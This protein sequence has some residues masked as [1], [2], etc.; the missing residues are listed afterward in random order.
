MATDNNSIDS[1]IKIATHN[2]SVTSEHKSMALNIIASKTG[3]HINKGIL[4]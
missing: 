3:I 4:K 1:L 2:K